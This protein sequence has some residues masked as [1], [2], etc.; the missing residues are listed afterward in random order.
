LTESHFGSG[1]DFPSHPTP[2]K[3]DHQSPTQE[4]FL[5]IQNE[6]KQVYA[7]LE[8]CKHELRNANHYI[9]GLQTEL[10]NVHQQ[11]EDAK[12][13]SEVRGKELFAT[14]VFLTKADTISIS[15]VGEKVTAL[16][17][18]IFQA[19]TL[20]EVLIHESHEMPRGELFAAGADS[21][22]MLGEK[23]TNLLIIQS[24]KPRP[25]VNSLLVQVV[26]QIFMVNFCVSKIQ[27]WY[28]GDSAIG[29]FLAA[30]FARPVS[31]SSDM[32]PNQPFA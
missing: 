12:N 31:I 4:D 16:N 17:E 20:G 19:A 13:L 3:G 11:L 29:D 5:R 27:S 18:E 32:T 30:I 23:M 25:E 26:L 1:S 15:E 10:N 6:L 24:Q 21:R 8:G 9:G 2:P 28:P 14:Q 22:E 7:D